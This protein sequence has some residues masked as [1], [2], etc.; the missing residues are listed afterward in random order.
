MTKNN[1]KLQSSAL[2]YSITFMLLIG[3]V[4]SG[5][6]FISSANKRIETV[7]LTKERVIFDHFFSLRFASKNNLPKNFELV[8]PTGD[9][10]SII[11]Q[12]WGAFK[13]VSIKTHHQNQKLEQTA[14]I[15]YENKKIVPA[16]YLVNNDLSLKIGGETKIEGD[17]YLP[18]NGVERSYVSGKNYKGNEL[19]YGQIHKSAKELPKLNSFFKNIDYQSFLEDAERREFQLKD[20][21]FSFQNNTTIY[22]SI[23][24]ILLSNKLTGNLIIHSFDSIFVSKS[25]ELNYV[26]LISPVIRFEKGF[27]G[28]VQAIASERISCEENVFLSYPS[29][30]ILNQ[31]ET[32]QKELKKNVSISLSDK[33]KVLGGILITSQKLNT[34]N[35]PRLIIK[36]KENSE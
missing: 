29:T 20:S 35:Y 32:N 10:S 9:T 16:L 2:A 15:G 6:I 18:E 27:N 8:H 1:N 36:K 34:D 4:C 17:V 28:N 24:P 21:N 31:K 3:L 7:Y 13:M 26:I 33:C 22:S 25:A 11:S 23:N 5:V 19:I 30:L 14:L 12:N